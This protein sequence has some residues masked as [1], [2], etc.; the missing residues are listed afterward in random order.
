MLTTGNSDLARS[1]VFVWSLPALVAD[2]ERHGR[3]Q[4]CPHAGVC[5]T[6]CYARFGTYRFP[7]VLAAH[8]ENL[9]R[10]LDYP[11]RWES[12]MLREL[13]HP[14]Y[15]GAWVRLHDGGDFF[16]RWYAEAWCRIATRSPWAT[17]YA[18]TKEVSMWREL[19]AERPANLAIIFSLGGTEDHLIDRD[20]DRHAD[21]FASEEALLAAGYADQADDDRLAVMGPTK[22]GIVANNLPGASARQGDRSFGEWQRTRRRADGP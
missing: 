1:R 3:V 8:T 14:R 16:A 17:F 18:Y 7:A 10:V 4:T 12:A 19:E 21:V 6:A 9:D 22:V 5:A 11:A 13:R 20:A 2:T 15:R